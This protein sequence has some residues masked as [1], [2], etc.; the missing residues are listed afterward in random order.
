MP[1]QRCSASKC[2]CPTYLHC[3]WCN[4]PY[5]HAHVFVDILAP[6]RAVTLCT[7][8]F[9]KQ[10]EQMLKTINTWMAQGKGSLVADKMEVYPEDSP[11]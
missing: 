7:T 4:R 8:C 6:G 5:C 10:D 3:V 2:Q 1:V 11:W 9:Q